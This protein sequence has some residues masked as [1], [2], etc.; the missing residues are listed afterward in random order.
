MI[1]GRRQVLCVTHL[2]QIAALADRHFVVEKT[3]TGER[4]GSTVRALDEPGRSQEIARLIGGAEDAPAPASTRKTCSRR[5]G[6]AGRTR[7]GKN[8]FAKRLDMP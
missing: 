2:P 1:A 3:Q 5:Q 6:G 7:D 4:T 8:A